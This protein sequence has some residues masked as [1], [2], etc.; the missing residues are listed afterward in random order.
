MPTSTHCYDYTAQARDGGSVRVTC[1]MLEIYNEQ[2]FDL[3]NRSAKNL[4]VGKGAAPNAVH[5]DVAAV[6]PG[7]PPAV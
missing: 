7:H 1:S 3:L 6:I 4:K 5:C 2:V